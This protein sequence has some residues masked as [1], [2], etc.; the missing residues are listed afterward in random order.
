MKY[1]ENKNIIKRI[2][3]SDYVIKMYMKQSE[4]ILYTE[5]R[6]PPRINKEDLF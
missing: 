6:K 2:E 4:K 3:D 1:I 5:F